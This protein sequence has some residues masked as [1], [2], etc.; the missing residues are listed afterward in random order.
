MHCCARHTT[1]RGASV[2]PD[3]FDYCAPRRYAP[4]THSSCVLG[5]R[6][7]L[8]GTCLVDGSG[9]D[10]RDEVQP[11]AGQTLVEMLGLGSWAAPGVVSPSR[12]SAPSQAPPS[13]A[14]PSSGC[15]RRLQHADS[16]DSDWESRLRLQPRPDVVPHATGL[17]NVPTVPQNQ[18]QNQN[19]PKNP[20][21]PKSQSQ[22]KK[23]VG[24]PTRDLP[25]LVQATVAKFEQCP[26][27]T[28]NSD[29][30]L[31][32][33]DQYVTQKAFLIRLKK[34]HDVFLGNFRGEEDRLDEHLADRKKL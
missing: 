29:F 30:R 9:V 33:G 23:A 31:F 14:P 11:A 3:A 18:R 4:I 12:P 15:K 1:S 34:D 5:P 16:S 28:T 17:A 21:Q 25:A 24:R 32:F 20:S 13:E 27:N 6:K 10:T 22:P 8:R 2:A 19:Q 7:S 26:H